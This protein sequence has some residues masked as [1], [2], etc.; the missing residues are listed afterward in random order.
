ML[1]TDFSIEI[2]MEYV[3]HIDSRKQWNGYFQIS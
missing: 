2:T 3:E 1:S